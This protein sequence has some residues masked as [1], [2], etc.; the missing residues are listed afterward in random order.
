MT[1][2]DEYEQD[3]LE[4]VEA[5]EW[6]NKGNLETRLSELQSHIKNQKKKAISLR[7]N[8]KDIYEL[9]K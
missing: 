3:I 8:E 2:L 6:Q 1:I 9:K 4:S 5:G 7:I